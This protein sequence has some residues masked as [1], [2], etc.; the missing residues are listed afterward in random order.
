MGFNPSID[1]LPAA[2]HVSVA[3]ESVLADILR[4]AT[5]TTALVQHVVVYSGL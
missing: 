2:Q 5:Y 1:F 3:D 4:E